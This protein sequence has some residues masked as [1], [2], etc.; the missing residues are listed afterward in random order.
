M[1]HLMEGGLTTAS[2]AYKRSPKKKQSLRIKGFADGGEVEQTDYLMPR[3]TQERPKGALNQMVTTPAAG[4]VATEGQVEKVNSQMDKKGILDNAIKKLQSNMSDPT[5]IKEVAG[6]MLGGIQE[7]NE[8][9]RAQLQA[10]LDP[11]SE[12]ARWRSASRLFDVSAALAKPVARGSGF[13]GTL[14]NLAEAGGGF[15]KNKLAER[16]AN[17]ALE[18]E[19]AG[20]N[21]DPKILQTL[22]ETGA[23]TAPSS[24]FGKQALDE[25][26]TAGTPEF[27]QR[28]KQLHQEDVET[29]RLK[30]AGTQ[31]A[32][33]SFDK[34]TGN[35]ITPNGAVIKSKE[36]AEDREKL[37]TTKDLYQRMMDIAPSTLKQAKSVIDYTGSDLRKTLGGSFDKKTLQAQLEIQATGIQEILN[38]LPKGPASDKDIM[39]A[40]SSFPGYSDPV[41]LEA[42]M[43]RTKRMIERKHNQLNEKYGSDKW[44]GEKSV[45]EG[46]GNKD[47]PAK[48][49]AKATKELKGKT[50]YQHSDGSWHDE[51]EK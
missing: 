5:A 29:K 17:Q 42:W 45:S 1:N 49:K 11:N 44:Y 38:N 46:V 13:S 8:A 12:D 36:V 22:K 41:A 35:F 39:Q 3:V 51:D 31:I 20:L 9:R 32:G 37:Q 40:K 10:Q 18:K 30:S 14:A 50:Y 28:V 4:R 23:L 7:Q 21:F 25:G 6:A 43:E 15:A 47:A 33:G 19:M 24:N 27:A 48:V 16:Q 26:F 2:K 34:K